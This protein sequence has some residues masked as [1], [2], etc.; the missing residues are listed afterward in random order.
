MRRM[1]LA[2]SLALWLA[3]YA[4]SRPAVEKPVAQ[5][6]A[7]PA[8]EELPKTTDVLGPDR[9]ASLP[10]GRFVQVFESDPR[11]C[12]E[13]K[14]VR[15]S[16]DELVLTDVIARTVEEVPILGDLPYRWARRT[17]ANVIIT[18]MDKDL[19]IRRAKIAR[20]N[21]FDAEEGKQ[22]LAEQRSWR[23]ELG[24][25]G[26]KNQNRIQLTGNEQFGTDL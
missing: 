14:V 18:A 11:N 24:R 3:G 8:Q 15:A 22:R 4:S 19:T 5:K 9:L 26:Q 21:L 25:S 23:A 7:A 12:T 20:I 17:F 13:G 16:A 2:A 10:A 1:L 6:P